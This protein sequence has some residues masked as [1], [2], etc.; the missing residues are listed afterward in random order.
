[1]KS[2]NVNRTHETRYCPKHSP[3]GNTRMSKWNITPFP[4]TE[5]NALV[6]VWNNPKGLRKMI[7]PKGCFP[8]Y[9]VLP[10]TNTVAS[11]EI[12]IF[13]RLLLC[14]LC[15]SPFRLITARGKLLSQKYKIRIITS[16]RSISL[17]ATTSLQAANQV[18]TGGAS[19]RSCI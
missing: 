8:P 18:E 6:D 13:R 9:S 2:L 14:L 12:M 16:P 17:L 11:K 4:I 7:S 5:S 19:T 1:M 15:T 10:Y 3:P